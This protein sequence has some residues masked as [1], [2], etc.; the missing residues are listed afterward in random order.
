[1]EFQDFEELFN[2]LLIKKV[3]ISTQ[4]KIKYIITASL[5][6]AYKNKYSF[7]LIN[8]EEIKLKNVPGE[9]NIF[10]KE[11][12]GILEE[13]LKVKPNI[14]K[15]CLLLCLYTGLRIGEVCGLKWEDINFSNNSLIVNRTIIRIKNSNKNIKTKTILIASTPKS[16]SSVRVVPIPNFLIE[17]L[18]TFKSN[19]KYY[20]LS[21]S[22]TIYD[23]RLF[24]S[25]YKR[26]LEKCNIKY[27]KFHTIRHTFAT[28]AL[29]S[30]MD[31]KTLSEIMGHSSIEITLKLYVHPSYETKKIM[32]E[33]L[34]NYMKS[35]I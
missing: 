6:Y 4:K 17:I 15:L 32:I 26:I 7:K 18:K 28:R 34:V 8:L 12:Q 3:A 33:N 24:Q 31:I 14:R 27:I 22:E 29:E 2:N 11:N 13:N 35:N 23:P 5:N 19:D 1:M 10:S 21:Q 16:S 30:K 20:L 25:F 9:I